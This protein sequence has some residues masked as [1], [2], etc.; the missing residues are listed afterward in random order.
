MLLLD[1]NQTIYSSLAVQIKHI[2]PSEDLL[3]HMVLNSLRNYRTKFTPDYGEM[4]ICSDSKHSWRREFFPYYKHQRKVA[5]K[6]SGINWPEIFEYMNKLKHELRENFPYKYLEVDGAEADDI[7]ATVVDYTRDVPDPV[8]IISGDKDFMQLQV[9]GAK[10]YDPVRN[11][12]LST[13]S[14]DKFLIEHIIKGDR[15]DGI[16]NIKSSDNVFVM[17]DRQHVISKNFLTTFDPETST[18]EVRRNYFRNKKLIDLRETPPDIREQI[19]QQYENSVVNDRSK[20]FNYFVTHKL[21]NLM[22]SI[23]EF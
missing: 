3:R 6:K 17:H 20:L 12:W 10:Q 7:I 11:R 21:K 1:I 4:I 18:G 9:Y 14:P 19:I 13:P 16:P 15:S 22:Q 8:L 2:E 23:N 5:R